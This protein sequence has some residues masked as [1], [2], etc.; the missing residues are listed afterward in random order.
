MLSNAVQNLHFQ[1]V[2]AQRMTDKYAVQGEVEKVVAQL[3]NLVQADGS[4][5][6]ALQTDEEPKI[7]IGED[8]SGAPLLLVTAR[9]G[10]VQLECTLVLKCNKTDS[11]GRQVLASISETGIKGEYEVSDLTGIETVHYKISTPE[12]EAANGADQENKK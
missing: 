1:K 4:G 8:D 2:A 5:T 11:D 10:S 7:V 3:E 9:H 12:E 6:I